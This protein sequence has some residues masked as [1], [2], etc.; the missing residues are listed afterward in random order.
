MQWWTESSKQDIFDPERLCLQ[1]PDRYFVPV[2]DEACQHYVPEDPRDDR[3]HVGLINDNQPDVLSG[4]SFLAESSSFAFTI[5]LLPAV[6]ALANQPQPGLASATNS[7]SRLCSV[8]VSTRMP[9]DRRTQST[10]SAPQLLDRLAS[11]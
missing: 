11:Y 4:S 6:A 5:S 9:H 7:R 2:S 8:P 1:L 3:V 10:Y